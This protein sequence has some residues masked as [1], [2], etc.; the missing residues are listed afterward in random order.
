MSDDPKTP[1]WPDLMSELF[2]EADRILN[3]RSAVRP[4]RPSKI[5]VQ[6][7]PSQ[8]AWL[9]AQPGGLSGSLRR[10]VAAA[11]QDADAT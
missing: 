5:D 10:L 9:K 11:M 4:E 2:G 8:V 3:P 7:L 6:L 1:P